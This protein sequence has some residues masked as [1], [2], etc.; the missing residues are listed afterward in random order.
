MR[1]WIAIVGAFALAAGASAAAAEEAKTPVSALLLLN[2]M[3]APIESRVSAFDESLRRA[4]L[5][6]KPPAGEVQEDGSVR[7]GNVTVTVKNPC[8]PG[9]LHYEP[10][11]LPGRRAR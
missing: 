5:P 2:I 11:P 6:P 9:T 4:G 7:Y 1:T 8:P 10:L 3:S